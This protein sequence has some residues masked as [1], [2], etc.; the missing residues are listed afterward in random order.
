MD[1]CE[2][3]AIDEHGSHGVEEDLEGAE[4]CLA[5]EGIEEERLDCGGKVGVETCYS[6]GLVVRQMVGL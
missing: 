5:Q 1:V 2:W 4:E 3:W 6:E